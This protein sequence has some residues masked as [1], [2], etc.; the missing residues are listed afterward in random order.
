MK[1]KKKS[2]TEAL[3][4]LRHKIDQVDEAILKK[5]A[6]RQKLS[7][8]IGILKNDTGKPIRDFKREAA[9]QKKYQQLASTLQIEPAFVA[10]LFKIIITHSISVQ[11]S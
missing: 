3:E 2:Q 8:K 11:K 4:L 7:K 9:Q 10:K 5:I 1:N 6:I